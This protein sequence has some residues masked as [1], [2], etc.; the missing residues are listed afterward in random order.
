MS[1]PP[2]LFDLDD[3]AVPDKNPMIVKHGMK[4]GKACKDCEF[5]IRE[6][7]HDKTYFKCEIRGVSR[8]STTDH[9]LRWLACGLYKQKDE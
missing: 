6:K 3:Y 4:K 1:E 2:T 8:S 7:F 5:F 9:R